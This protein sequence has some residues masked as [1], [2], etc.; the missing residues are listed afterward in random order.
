M[1]RQV[2]DNHS[3]LKPATQSV[4]CSPASSQ[5]KVTS[6]STYRPPRRGALADQESTLELVVHVRA[7]VFPQPVRLRYRGNVLLR[8]DDVLPQQ[9][10]VQP[11]HLLYRIA[12]ALPRRV[13]VPVLV[14][15]PTFSTE[16]DVIV[17]QYRP[18]ECR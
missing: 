2:A 1:N 8:Q 12:V 18:R 15:T 5:D 13:D 6:S 10:D 3:P 7:F 14:L 9:D 16:Q 11:A 17:A 4:L